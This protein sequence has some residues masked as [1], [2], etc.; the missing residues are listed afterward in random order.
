[1]HPRGGKLT[2]VLPKFAPGAMTDF[3]PDNFFD[4]QDRA[5]R[6]WAFTCGPAKDDEQPDQQKVMAGG[7]TTSLA[8]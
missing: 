4:Q 1:M 3:L 7:T 6:L 8:T 5:L 2:G